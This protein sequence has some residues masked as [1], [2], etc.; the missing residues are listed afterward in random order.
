MNTKL[1]I[2]ALLAG[3]TF[4]SFANAADGTINFVGTISDVACT[5]TPDT[6][7][8][9]VKLGTISSTAFAASGDTASPTK[10]S[11]I[12]SSCP[13][14]LTSATVK[15]DGPTD[16]AN[17]SLVALTDVTGVAT[18]VGV[19]I[20]E[21]DS[22]TMIP[23][24]SA[25]ASIPLSAGTDTKIDFVAKYVATGTTVEAGEA[26]AVSDFTISYN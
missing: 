26:N 14:S 6:G 8:Q 18:G 2:V 21:S 22:S 7:N 25:S 5:I 15:F 11:V 13:A 17:S 16:S 4:A 9:Q 12:L 10:F 19:G 1:M 3:S 24:G 23:V 20:Y